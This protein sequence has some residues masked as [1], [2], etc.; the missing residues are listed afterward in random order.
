MKV[1]TSGYR[2]ALPNRENPDYAQE[3]QFVQKEPSKLQVGEG[4]R[5][6]VTVTDGTTNEE[7]LGMLLN[8]LMFLY[9]QLPDINTMLAAHHVELALTSL[10]NRSADR[11]ARGVEGTA[12]Q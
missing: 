8:R 7:V 5:S 1:L 6:L 2:Y 3:L 9:Q 10:H 12:Q 4:P 11:Q